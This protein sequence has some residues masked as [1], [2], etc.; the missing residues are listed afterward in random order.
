M[1]DLYVLPLIIH[2]KLLR[3]K[4]RV[5]L[6][7]LTWPYRRREWTCPLSLS[8]VYVES[9]WKS[10]SQIL[11]WRYLVR[12]VRSSHDYGHDP[13][14]S[15]QGVCRERTSLSVCHPLL[16]SFIYSWFVTPFPTLVSSYPLQNSCV[17][18]KGC[19]SLVWLTH[20][21]RHVPSVGVISGSSLFAGL[22]PL[23]SHTC[24]VTTTPGLKFCPSP[25]STPT[26]F[27]N[28]GLGPVGEYSPIPGMSSLPL[29]SSVFWGHVSLG[30]TTNQLVSQGP[31]LWLPVGWF[32]NEVDTV[33]F[34]RSRSL[35]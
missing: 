12:S 19:L 8:V 20:L 34:L 17:S 18:E 22:I 13:C 7:I 11:V 6:G 33:V 35:I 10:W 27:S 9:L 30:T 23:L 5:D 2:C 31:S 3:G 28:T 4:C 16:F 14:V 21:V 1:T 25:L 24:K 29:S 32:K 26:S 15:T